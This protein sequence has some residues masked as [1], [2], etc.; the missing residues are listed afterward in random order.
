MN[1]VTEGEHLGIKWKIVRFPK[2]NGEFGFKTFIYIDYIEPYFCSIY[3]LIKWGRSYISESNLKNVLHGLIQ[4]IIEQQYAPG[5]T[6]YEESENK[7]FLLIN[8]T[9]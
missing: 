2:A 6:K 3:K 5:G 4:E 1:K 9:K 8:D 7:I